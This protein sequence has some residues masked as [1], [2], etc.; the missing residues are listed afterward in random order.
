MYIFLR[1]SV[2]K[3]LIANRVIT[4]VLKITGSLNPARCYAS[5]TLPDFALKREEIVIK[6][7]PVGK[8]DSTKQLSSNDSNP[9]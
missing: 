7:T 2:M 8:L 6:K 3:K 1:G 5:T 9:G 4:A